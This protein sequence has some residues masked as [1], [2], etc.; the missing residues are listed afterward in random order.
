[1]S[2][3]VKNN[4]SVGNNNTRKSKGSSFLIDVS[5]TE[6][7][8]REL[9][10]NLIAD[11]TLA[12]KSAQRP[13]AEQLLEIAKA[14]H[15]KMT[16]EQF[17]PDPAAYN[18]EVAD[19]NLVQSEL[20]SVVL[21]HMM[22]E[23]INTSKKE[24]EDTKSMEQILASLS[25][26]SL[27]PRDHSSVD[28]EAFRRMI[29]RFTAK[30]GGMI[31]TVSLGRPPQPYPSSVP[32]MNRPSDV[33]FNQ[34]SRPY[35][36]F[37][38]TQ[39]NRSVPPINQRMK[40]LEFNNH[41]WEPSS[42]PIKNKSVAIN[43]HKSTVNLYGTNI[44]APRQPVQSIVNNPMNRM[45]QVMKE[46]RTNDKVL[47][48]NQ[49]TVAI[50][51]D[52]FYQMTGIAIPIE[53]FQK[54]EKIVSNDMTKKFQYVRKGQKNIKRTLA[55]HSKE[56]FNV[57]QYHSF[58][59]ILQ[60]I[61][62][63]HTKLVND[64]PKDMFFGRKLVENGVEVRQTILDLA[65]YR[66]DYSE[67]S[68][69]V[70]RTSPSMV[71][72]MGAPIFGE[73]IN[74]NIEEILIFYTK[75]VQN[76]SNIYYIRSTP[77]TLD[78]DFLPFAFRAMWGSQEVLNIKDIMESVK[79]YLELEPSYAGFWFPD[80]S[81]EIILSTLNGMD[82]T[83][84]EIVSDL[85]AVTQIMIDLTHLRYKD[86]MINTLERIVQDPSKAF[87]IREEANAIQV[88]ISKQASEKQKMSSNT[89]DELIDLVAHMAVTSGKLDMTLKEDRELID[90]FH[91]TK[92][93]VKGAFNDIV[94]GTAET[95]EFFGGIARDLPKVANDA[96]RMF[97]RT[98]VLTMMLLLFLNYLKS[99]G[100]IRSFMSGGTGPLVN[101]GLTTIGVISI[102]QILK[103]VSFQMV[104]PGWTSIFMTLVGMYMFQRG[105]TSKAPVA[106]VVE[107]QQR[108]ANMA[109]GMP[110][111]SPAVSSVV[112]APAINRNVPAIN[113]NLPAIMSVPAAPPS[114]PAIMMNAP[115]PVPVR[116]PRKSRWDNTGKSAVQT[117][118]K[119]R[120]DNTAPKV[121][122]PALLEALRR[123][124]L[125]KNRLTQKAGKRNR[126]RNVTRRR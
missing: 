39:I 97:I 124:A 51:A 61:R 20:M 114:V 43:T 118:R 21:L 122:D 79:G 53:P 107:A 55:I 29:M 110:L 93:I 77:K 37:Q 4:R 73:S 90:F 33:S 92:D 41:S 104:K 10:M 60:R 86:Y 111:P 50:W 98:E 30:R 45:E 57:L 94:D 95:V 103:E 19:E 6:H 3:T 8:Q 102:E 15:P 78:T 28:P 35:G 25:T 115:K 38:G 125:L 12:L 109:A 34:P 108:A 89:A 117:P 65:N 26:D 16:M 58:L 74:Y 66:A 67:I 17:M 31:R 119:S 68:V 44:P 87:A 32:S 70:R 120:W 76:E 59:N 63:G 54:V 75:T 2:S 56:R 116:T 72:K 11:E 48:P 49:R 96:R 27:L 18:Q 71:Q 24:G 80:T 1:M 23:V 105:L 88:A 100:F 121:S 22:N 9:F 47:T 123:A 91:R 82:V 14:L 13:T 84:K 99:W 64:I 126:R 106:V 112:A 52:K 85:G 46:Y 113:R 69:Y 42:A 62:V 101:T 5:G 83:T 40:H 7:D 81:T 36:T